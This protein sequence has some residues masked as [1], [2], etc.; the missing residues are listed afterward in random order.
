MK[1]VRYMETY[2]FCIHYYYTSGIVILDLNFYQDINLSV[3]FVYRLQE[4]LFLQ[5]KTTTT[6][7]IIHSSDEMRS[8]CY[9]SQ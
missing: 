1:Y 3:L 7:H 5:T 9:N 6:T 4:S 2:A 8:I